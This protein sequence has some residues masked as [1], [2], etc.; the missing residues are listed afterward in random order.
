MQKKRRLNL[1]SIIVKFLLAFLL[2][3]TL[4]VL[5]TVSIQN[6]LAQTT[7][8][9]L[10]A[11]REMQDLSALEKELGG[12]V[13][14]VRDH[15]L[16]NGDVPVGDG[17]Y[18]HANI[19]PF[20]KTEQETASFVYSFISSALADEAVLARCA[21][22]GRERTAL[23]R[24]AGSTLD[25]EGKPIVGTF[26][27]SAIADPLMENGTFAGRSY[28]E[29][30]LFYCYY[31][32]IRGADG[33]PLGA[34]VAG[35][36]IEELEQKTRKSALNSS[37]AVGVIIL[38]TFLALFLFV[39]KWNRAIRR[40][41][42]YLKGIGSGQFPQTPLKISGGDELSEMADVINEMKQSLEE[43]ERLRNELALART[44]QAGL[45]P[46]ESAAQSLPDVCRVCGFM[47]PAREV[48]GDLYDFFMIDGD[49][50]GLVIADVS[51]K[52][53]PAALFMA[54]AK[55]CIKDNMML[56]MEPAAVLNLVNDRLLENNKLRLFV[57]AWIGVVELSTGIMRYAMA[58]HPFP[59]VLRADK[60]DYET[61]RSDRNLVLAGLP[62]FEFRQAETVL[63]PGDRLFLYT[64]G[65]DE[66]RDRNGGFFGRQRVEEYLD[67]HSR[68]GVQETIAGIKAAVDEF[69]AGREQ[70]D[71]LTL[72][73]MAYGGGTG[74][75]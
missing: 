8:E 39:A 37:L 41:E 52:G 63:R 21:A 34:V 50:L 55:M 51:D 53:T 38:Y 40:T 18:E 22:E 26:L 15:V 4:L 29:G 27:D 36:S 35:R 28:V 42:K 47:A 72:L 66:A 33:V 75:E 25:A 54:T 73:M 74:H 43:R 19:A 62:G 16:Y 45:L 11:A 7:T 68:L 64:D 10:T 32:V 60:N 58:G 13:W 46:D 30:R 69:A 56:G 59:F 17:T 1:H 67:A 14:N 24:V 65:L 48:G 3:G 44:I 49:H 12:G 31:S 2:F 9:E 71:D 61:L 23:L 5:I 6:D 20:L 57:T 70:Y